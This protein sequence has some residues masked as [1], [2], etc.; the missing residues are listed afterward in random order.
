M[1]TY[2]EESQTLQRLLKEKREILLDMILK[3][4]DDAQMVFRRMYSHKNL[5]LPL[6]EVVAIMPEEN[7]DWAIVQAENTLKKHKPVNK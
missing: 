5:E 6:S 2:K 4:S 1:K 7:L 3:C